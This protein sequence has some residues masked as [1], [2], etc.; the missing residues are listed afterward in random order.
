MKSNALQEMVSKI[1]SD[2]A[3][4]SQFIVNPDSVI[5]KYELSEQEKRAVLS[6]HAKLGLVTGDSPQLSAALKPTFNWCIA[7]PI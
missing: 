4:K 1:F 7:P 6:T 5:S 3:T 2:E